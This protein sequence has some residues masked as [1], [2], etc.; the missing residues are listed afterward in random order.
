MNARTVGDLPTGRCRVTLQLRKQGELTARGEIIENKN[1]R[2][3][4]YTRNSP[5]KSFSPETVVLKYRKEA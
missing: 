1:R 5:V 3:H 2:K 4:F